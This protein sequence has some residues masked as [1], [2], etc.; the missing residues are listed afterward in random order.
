MDTITKQIEEIA[1]DFCD[2]YCKYP[3]KYDPE[4]HDGV[5]LF[6]S[7]ICQNCPMMRL[8]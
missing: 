3:E 2:N 6:D 4:E 8:V 1:E 7:D 5:E